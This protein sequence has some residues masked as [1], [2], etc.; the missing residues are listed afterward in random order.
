[1]WTIVGCGLLP[2][3]SPATQHA[4]ITD[5]FEWTEKGQT[6]GSSWVYIL[7]WYRASSS[8]RPLAWFNTQLPPS[9]NSYWFYLSSF[10]LQV[11]SGGTV[12]HQQS[13]DMKEKKLCLSKPLLVFSPCF[14]N[15]GGG[16][17]FF[18]GKLCRQVSSWAHGIEV[19]WPFNI[20]SP[21]HFWERKGVL[22]LI[23]LETD[24]NRTC[25]WHNGRH[26]YSTL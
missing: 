12:G 11:R 18:S 9:W 10:I 23:I 14:L 8:E 3:C 22:S 1:M 15:K 21:L 20:L 24:A 4:K 13:R 25:S 7:W 26:G 2:V 6:Q 5:P 19:G 16:S 17:H